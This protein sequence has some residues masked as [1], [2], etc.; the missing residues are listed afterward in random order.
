MTDRI[1]NAELYALNHDLL[2]DHLI[3]YLDCGDCPI[4]PHIIEAANE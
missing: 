1:H 2:C 3:D 4:P